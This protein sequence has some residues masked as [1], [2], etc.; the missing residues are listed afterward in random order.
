MILH[1]NPIFWSLF[2]LSALFFR[3]IFGDYISGFGV[4]AYWA[5]SCWM[6]NGFHFRCAHLWRLLFSGSIR[7]RV[8]LEKSKT[9]NGD[10]NK[11]EGEKTF[12]QRQISLQSCIHLGRSFETPHWLTLVTEC[13][14]CT[15]SLSGM[16]NSKRYTTP[17]T[18]RTS[19]KRYICNN[20]LQYMHSTSDCNNRLQRKCN[21]RMQ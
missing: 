19:C 21:G 1:W 13:E 17:L 11:W 20:R 10:R 18:T 4:W 8:C 5:S 12:L 6:N 3:S 9:S 7:D 2:F 14:I 16:R 15:A